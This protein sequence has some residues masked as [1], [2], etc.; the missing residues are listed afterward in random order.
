MAIEIMAAYS[1]VKDEARE[2]EP[3]KSHTTSSSSNSLGGRQLA[4]ALAMKDTL[5]D[6]HCNWA[7]S[8][9]LQLG[10]TSNVFCF[11]MAP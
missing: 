7:Q 9:H 6:L 2:L 5:Q 11:S 4:L 1:L 3:L 8:I 10:C